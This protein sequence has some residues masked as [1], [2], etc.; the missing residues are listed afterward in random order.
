[1]RARTAFSSAAGAVRAA[2]AASAPVRTLNAPIARLTGTTRVRGAHAFAALE[3]TVMTR[4]FVSARGF[5]SDTGK[6]GRTLSEALLEERAHE[7]AA[8][9]PSASALKI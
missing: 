5:A 6:G 9:E 2:F 1:M 3:R 4:A 8:Y 7:S